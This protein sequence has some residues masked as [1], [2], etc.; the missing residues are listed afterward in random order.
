[1]SRNLLLITILLLVVI[2]AL[3]WRVEGFDV[4]E[5]VNDRTNPLAAVTNA[6]KNPAVPVGISTED[7]AAERTKYSV[8]FNGLAQPRIDDENSFNGLVKFCKE[9]G[10]GDSPFSNA[11]F[12]ENCGVCVSEG[13]VNMLDASGNTVRFSQPTGV[14]VYKAD[15]DRAM[16]AKET[17]NDIFPHVVPSMSAGTCVGASTG[18]DAK[19][20]LALNQKDL[21]AFKKRIE[22]Q[23][24]HTIGG[25]CGLCVNPNVYSYVPADA[26][27]STLSLRFWG[28][29]SI[30]VMLGGSTLQAIGTPGPDASGNWPIVR[31]SDTPVVYDLGAV[32]EGTSVEVNVESTGRGRW[33]PPPHVYGILMAKNSRNKDYKLPFERFME[34]DRAS[35][36][37]PRYGAPRFFSEVQRA[38][39]QVRP[40]PVLSRMQL[41][42]SIP[43]TLVHADQLAAYDCPTS[44]LTTIQASAELLVEDPCLNPKG[45]TAGNYSEDC[46][47]DAVTSAGCSVDGD[48]YKRPLDVAGSSSVGDFIAWIKAQV[49]KTSTDINAARGCLGKDIRTPCDNYVTGAGATQIPSKQC[50]IYTFKNTS[51]GSR[52]GRSYRGVWTGYSSLDN[53]KIQFCQPDG[54]LNPET[55]EGESRLRTVAADGYKGRRGLDAVRTYLSDVYVKAT[56]QLDVNK[57]DKDGGRKDSWAD[58]FGMP[59]AD[60]KLGNVRVL[61][62]G[63]VQKTVVTNCENLPTSYI[64]RYNTNIGNV[65]MTGDYILSFTI[66][67]TGYNWNWT[68]IVRFMLTNTPFGD[69]CTPGQRSPAIWFWPGATNL[70]VRI[71]DSTNGNWG[72]DTDPLPMNQ[73]SKFR[74]ECRGSAVTLSVNSRFYSATQPTSRARGTARVY[75]GDPWYTPAAATITEFCYTVL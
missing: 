36:S 69:C 74:L 27:V 6:L 12:A 20:V 9:N 44:P 30:T 66:T 21:V 50:L 73:P 65:N 23:K 52:V 38:L 60:P 49:P 41:V 25:E 29:G 68:N 75:G 53:R 63:Q 33:A 4:A 56:S 17:N 62:S 47:R 7:A 71:G 67:P 40:S 34:T 58:C 10:S 22:C 14:L 72:I 64:P 11:K 46:L 55:P 43:V 61:A 39:K 15:K 31:L 26:G 8:A 45:Q 42:G 59:I 57:L 35:N 54:R 19:P 51:E 18:T 2:L 70:H 24:N 37:F 13:T 32:P 5:L 28:T 3:S 1:M 48:W 16:S